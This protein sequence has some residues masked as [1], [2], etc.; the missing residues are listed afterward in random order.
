MSDLIIDEVID[1]FRFRRVEPR[2]K[3]LFMAVRSETSDVSEFYRRHP[4]YV[5]D[6][7]D[8][9]LK[10]ENE[11]SMVVFQQPDNLFVGTCSFQGVQKEN[12]ELGYDIAKDLQGK[13]IGSKMVGAL[14]KAAHKLFPEREIYVRIRK[15]NAASRRVAEKNGAEFI[16]LDDP[17]E[18]ATLQ[19]LLDQNDDLPSAAAARETI[20][21]SR[22]TVRLYKV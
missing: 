18:V 6:S 1:G 14:F 8:L 17:P 10:D 7:W 2:D 12:L 5:D 9:I 20:E 19:K 11:L 22:N 15:E 4:D 21:Q 13:G 16:R 3:D